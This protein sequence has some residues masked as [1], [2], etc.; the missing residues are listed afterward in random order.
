MKHRN[1]P[2]A[3]VSLIS[4]VLV[5]SLAPA[6]LADDHHGCSNRSVAGPY[7]Y[8]SS[9]NRTGVGAVAAVGIATLDH[10]G[11][12]DGK[13]TISFNGAAIAVETFTGT[14]TVNPDCTGSFIV[15]VVSPIAPRTSTLDVVWDDDSSQVRMIFTNTGTVITL[16]GRKMFSG[17][18]RGHD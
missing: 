6:A 4:A 15:D 8:T 2:T 3:L 11:N 14:Y 13:Q 10:D 12:L 16:E 1:L 5:A 7:G 17:R 9:G 18:S